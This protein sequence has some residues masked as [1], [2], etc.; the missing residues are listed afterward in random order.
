M[1]WIDKFGN[2]TGPYSD[3]QV[4]RLVRMCQLRKLDKISKDRQNWQRVNAT[5]FWN[6]TSAR[7]EEIEV[8]QTP[9]PKLSMGGRP[10][11]VGVAEAGR[12]FQP[13]DDISPDGNSPEPPSSPRGLS[14]NGWLVV[15]VVVGV[16][17]LAA[18]AI[19]LVRGG[20]HADRAASV[21]ASSVCVSND[22]EAVKRRVALIHTKE[23][24]GTGFLVAMNGKKYLMTNEHVVRSESTPEMVLVDGTKL[25]LGAF[26]V[27]KDRDLARFEV[28]PT[29]DCFE[30]SSRIP[31]NNDE[32]WIYGNSMGDDVI[33]TLRGFITGVGSK[34]LKTNAEIVG[35]NSGS[36]ILG[37]DG[38]VMAV[39]AYLRNGDKGRDWTTKDTAFDGVR[40]FGVRLADVAWVSVDRKRDEEACRKLNRIK[41]YFDYLHPYLICLKVS[42]EKRET[43]KLEQKDVDRK[44]FENDSEGFHEMLMAVSLS[45]ARQGG[46]LR[47]WLRLIESRELKTNQLQTDRTAGRLTSEQAQAALKEFDRRNKLEVVWETVK[48]RHRDF[49]AKRKE[50]L[51][52]ARGVLTGTDWQNPQIRHGDDVS[53]EDSVNGQLDYI[54]YWMDQNMQELKDLNKN[55]KQ[56]ENGDNEE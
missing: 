9:R 22:F 51:L 46:S 1:W 44:A 38:K 4:A 53:K 48:S 24:S 12:E 42:D 13:Q 37:A 47:K 16:G 32:I 34:V 18:V 17:L 23:G 45:Y 26:S 2:V 49:I 52:L 55:L 35:G 41:T 19:R 30:L 31:N 14:R 5:P 56:L 10:P 40:R 15:V 25:R 28:D 39:A 11:L 6:P 36:P 54:K 20:M 29:V 27:A 8:P 50:A 33:T 3:E 7:P 43:L 21:A